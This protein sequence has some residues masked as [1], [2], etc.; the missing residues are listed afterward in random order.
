MDDGALFPGNGLLVR[1][2]GGSVLIDTGREG[3]PQPRTGYQVGSSAVAR[4]GF[5]LFLF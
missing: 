2:D 3:A 4:L 1:R 5:D